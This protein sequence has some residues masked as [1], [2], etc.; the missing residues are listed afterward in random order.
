MAVPVAVARTLR[1]LIVSGLAIVALT[2]AGGWALERARF[3][4]DPASARARLEREV[5]AQFESLGGHLERAV[6]AVNVDP[7]TLRLAEQQDATATRQL[8]DRVAAGAA[9]ASP[10]DVAITVYSSNNL[11]LAWNRGSVDVPDVRLT[12]PPS[13]FLGSTARGLQ[14]V[15][16]EPLLDFS[17][18]R[19]NVGAT[20]ASVPLSSGESAIGEP[21]FLLTT[22]IV[23]VSVRPGFEAESVLSS[24]SFLVRTPAGEPLAVVGVSSDSLLEARWRFR[25]RR[26]ALAL[27]VLAVLGLLLI[28]PLLDWRRQSRSMWTASLL[29]VA[30]VALLLAARALCWVALRQADFAAPAITPTGSWMPVLS[31]M[32]ASPVD[33]ALTSLLL[34]ALAGLAVTT[35][36]LWRVR[37]RGEAGLVVLDTPGRGAVFLLEQ[38]AAGCALGFIVTGYESF[39]QVHV[40]QVP[41]DFLR[42][43]LDPM[44]PIRLFVVVG[45]V[46]LNLAV[47]SLSILVLR[48]GQASWVFPS[49]RTGWRLRAAVVWLTPAMLVVLSG[50]FGT[51]AP[52]APTLILAVVAVCAALLAGRYRTMLRHSSQAVRL[53]AAFAMLVLPSL[54]MYPSLVNAALDARRQLIELRYA[55]E[56]VNQRRDVRVRLVE[57]LAQIDRIDAIADLVRAVD[58]PDEG[59]P[60]SDAAFLIWSQTGLST[61]RMT[62]SVELYNAEGSLVSRFALKLPD[63]PQPWTEA[64]CDWEV[65]EEV[66]PFFSEER[67]LLHAGRQ[68]CVTGPDGRRHTAGSLVVDVTLDY[69]N[70]SFISAQNPYVALMRSSR[71]VPEPR[72]RADVEFTVYGWSRRVLYTSAQTAQ[73]LPEDVFQRAYASREPFWVTVNRQSDVI[74]A[75]VMNDRGAIYLLSTVRQTG[76]GHLVSLAELVTLIFVIFAVAMSLA[77]VASFASVRIPIS[78]RELMHEV[79]ASFY[80]KL[81]LAFVAAAIVPVLALALVSR[82]YVAALMFADI[83]SE[84]TRTASLVSRVIEDVGTLQARTA[85]SQAVVD[86]NIVVWLSRVIAQDVNI[87]EGADLLASSERNLFASGLLPTRTPGDAYRAILL[88]GRP[89]HVGRESAG[90]LEYIVAAAPVRVRDHDAILTVPLTSRQQETEAQ[91]QELDRRVLLAALLFIMLGAGIGYYMAERIADPV[92][93]LMRATKRIARGDLDARVL[94]TSSDEL[95]QLVEAFNGMAVDLQRQRQELERTNRLAAW[96]DMARQVAHDIKNPLTPIQLNAEHIRRVHSDRGQPLGHVVDESVGLILGQVRLLRQISSEFSSFAASPAPK[97]VDANLAEL[98]AEVIDPYRPGLAGRILV[99]VD[100]GPSLPLLHID[101]MLIGRALTN[102]IENALHAMPGTGSLTVIVEGAGEHAVRIRVVDSGVGMDADALARIFEPYFSSRAIGTGLGLTIAKRNVEANGGTIEVESQP[103]LGTTATITLPV[104]P[105]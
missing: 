78:G 84:A 31:V 91:I 94:A 96:A 53:F 16:I 6:R 14:L 57:A 7:Q 63:S 67:L 21:A 75:Y 18:V 43:S 66:S 73:P 17:E 27:T 99:E 3:G 10:A 42:F 2:W 102:V 79:R 12:G 54:L 89:S 29:T 25:E 19:R 87:F 103:G 37:R 41:V 95:R 9:A 4:A 105:H 70:L 97:L 92:N 34:A 11:P 15:R 28:G 49:A 88:E 76:V 48:I 86:E 69:N 26:E 81:F 77:L 65:F 90:G 23:P 71:S 98:V 56:V 64:S 44:D 30:I 13:L 61:Q 55:P 100:L 1:R 36:S 85:P 5:A 82:A 22:S 47:V 72:P 59:P 62:S 68:Q 46:A 33:F 50:V 83:E 101:R 8:F 38:L 32:L 24:E 35:F 58:P 52:A 60:P 104:P 39:L 45:L 51:R 80:R 93:R 20:V 40:A 74:D